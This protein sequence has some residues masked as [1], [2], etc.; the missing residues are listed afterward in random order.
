MSE[1]VD[2]VDDLRENNGEDCGGRM[3]ADTLSK[4]GSCLVCECL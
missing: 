1:G 2:G 4:G 3:L